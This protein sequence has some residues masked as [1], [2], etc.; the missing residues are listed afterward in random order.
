LNAS[1]SLVDGGACE[2]WINDHWIGDLT[3]PC[4]TTPA[5]NLPARTY[6]LRVK[7]TRSNWGAHSLWLFEDNVSYRG[8]VGLVTITCYPEH[9]AK[10]MARWLYSS[11]A[12]VG[13]L[14]HAFGVGTAFES[15]YQGKVERLA[16][17][18]RSLPGCYE[19]VVYLDSRDAFVVG[20]ED[21]VFARL[22]YPVL[23]GM[24]SGPWPEQGEQWASAFR[25]LVFRREA[26]TALAYINA[27][28]FA[29]QREVLIGC[30]DNMTK[31][32]Q[33]WMAG[34]CPDWL[35]PYRH[36][37]DDQFLWQAYYRVDPTLIRL[38]TQ[39]ELLCNMSWQHLEL[40]HED[41]HP[42]DHRVA[43]QYGTE[44]LFLHFSGPGTAQLHHWFYWLLG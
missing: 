22:S 7:T 42:G 9:R 23:V 17:W 19:Q 13:W 12:R 8:R 32:R 16:S 21:Q 18:L 10:E 41:I 28:M 2:F 15:M 36:F 25:E 33:R 38:D 39:A 35:K 6:R 11:A 30:L 44:P 26:R 3:C 14:V 1:A 20:T 4:E 27:G 29:G 24:E 31:L 40:A 34:D 37:S 43:T 5:I